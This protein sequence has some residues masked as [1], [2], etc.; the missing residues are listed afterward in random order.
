[1]F[2]A[3]KCQECFWGLK[4]VL[5][6]KKSTITAVKGNFLINSEKVSYYGADYSMASLRSLFALVPWSAC[7]PWPDRPPSRA[8]DEKV[9]YR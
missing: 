4:I 3:L 8:M 1:M 9:S 6:E 7:T 2:E 5:D